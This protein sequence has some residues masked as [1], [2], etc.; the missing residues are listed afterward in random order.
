MLTLAA[1]AFGSGCAKTDWIGRT[2]VTVDVTGSWYG[3][4]FLLRAGSTGIDGQGDSSNKI[5]SNKRS[6]AY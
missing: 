2:L 4:R 6:G 3:R 1:L 5:R